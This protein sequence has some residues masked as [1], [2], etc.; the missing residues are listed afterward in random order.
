[1]SPTHGD[2]CH[3][4]CPPRP[5]SSSVHF[6][7]GS[8]VPPPRSP[9]PPSSVRL[10]SHRAMALPPTTGA[11]GNRWTIPPYH[12]LLPRNPD[13]PPTRIARGSPSSLI[14]RFRFCPCRLLRSPLSSSRIFILPGLAAEKDRARERA[15]G[16][17]FHSIRLQY[18]EPLLPSI[19]ALP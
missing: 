1:M 12:L 4:A 2:C 6:T 10:F 11:A 18:E 5:P 3:Q 9:L 17:P 14:A 16:D 7:D 13:R 8:S 19:R 15:T